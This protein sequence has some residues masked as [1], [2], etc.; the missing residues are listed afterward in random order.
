MEE[1]QKNC[2][3]FYGSQTEIAEEY[4]TKLAQE[5]V[6]RIGLHNMAVNL[7][8]YDYESLA[9]FPGNMATFFALATHGEGE[10]MDKAFAF[11]QFITELAA[12]ELG[13]G[14]QF[15]EL[16]YIIFGLSNST[17][18]KF[19]ATTRNIDAS[20]TKLGAQRLGSSKKGNGGSGTMEDFHTWKES[21]WVYFSRT[22]RPQTAR[23]SFT[24]QYCRFLKTHASPQQTTLF[25]SESSVKGILRVAKKPPIH[26]RTHLLPR[27]SNLAVYSPLKAGTVS[28]WKSVSR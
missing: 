16:K 3:V 22:N 10:P 24:S 8:D 27:L 11:H 25:I 17:Y 6:Q 21:T 20:L 12:G 15:S 2:D 28:M 26:P 9:L 4:A 7:A 1:N 23:V 5:G 14:R 19:N 18:K 13:K